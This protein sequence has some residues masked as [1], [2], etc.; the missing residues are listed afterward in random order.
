MLTIFDWIT[1]LGAMFSPGDDIIITGDYGAAIQQLD[2]HH[3]EHR[4]GQ[5][6]PDGGVIVKVSNKAWALQVLRQRGISAY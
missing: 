2:A 1:P 3:I 6:T 4:W 5:D